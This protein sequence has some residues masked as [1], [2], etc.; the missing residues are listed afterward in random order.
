VC[1]PASESLCLFAP[2]DD[3]LQDSS[4]HEEVMHGDGHH[5]VDELGN[6]ED[7]TSPPLDCVASV[8]DP[9]NLDRACVFCENWCRG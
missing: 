1:F 2:V 8:L 4:D 9:S 5:V 7:T 3:L 6:Y